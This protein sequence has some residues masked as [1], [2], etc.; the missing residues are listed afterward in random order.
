MLTPHECVG[1]CFLLGAHLV[2]ESWGLD[3]YTLNWPGIRFKVL[4][5]KAFQSAVPQFAKSAIQKMPA[6]NEG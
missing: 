2:D 4:F 1:A 6:P 3:P 5:P